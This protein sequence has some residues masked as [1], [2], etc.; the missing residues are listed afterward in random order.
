MMTIEQIKAMKEK[1]GAVPYKENEHGEVFL[2]ITDGY[3][4]ATTYRVKNKCPLCGSKFVKIG[5]HFGCYDGEWT[6]VDYF[7]CENEC[8]L[9]YQQIRDMKNVA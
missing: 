7:T 1:N 8:S 2:Y 3:G 4:I 6:S 9:T 5:N